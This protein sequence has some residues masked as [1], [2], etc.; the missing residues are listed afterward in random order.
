MADAVNRRQIL[1]RSLAAV[2]A[3][4]FVPGAAR[5]TPQAMQ[6]AIRAIVGESVPQHGARGGSEEA[7]PGNRG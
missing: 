4:E 5:A 7:I 3:A 1:V 6:E 2:V